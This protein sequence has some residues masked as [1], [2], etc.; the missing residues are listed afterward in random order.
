[1]PKYS[2]GQMVLFIH[3]QSSSNYLVG[4]IQ[5]VVPS[6]DDE[7]PSHYNIL[8]ESLQCEL[9]VCETEIIDIAY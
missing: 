2:E 5:S 8:C 6:G 1:M 4:M 9:F 3:K 7:H